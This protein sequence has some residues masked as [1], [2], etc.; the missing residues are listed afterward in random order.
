MD[1]GGVKPSGRRPRFEAGKDYALTVDVAGQDA[2]GRPLRSAFEKEFRATGADRTPPDP[3]RWQVTAP[4]A[5]TREALVVSF[6]EPM[7]HALA[8]RLIQVTAGVDGGSA[9]EGES[10]LSERE[11][12]WSF[13]PAQPWR[14]GPHRL[15]VATTIEDLAGNNIGKTFDVDLFE[16]VQRRITTESVNVEFGVK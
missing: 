7:D 6:D 13:E 12:R 16:G 2:A 8:L 4:K 10:A 9:L 14:R 5:G 3:R 1:Q 15:V 11:R